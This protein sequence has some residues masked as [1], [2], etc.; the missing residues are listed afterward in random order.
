MPPFTFTTTSMQTLMR[1]AVVTLLT[2]YASGA[3]IKLQVY[4]GRPRTLYPPAAFPDSMSEQTVFTGP[5]N[6]QRTVTIETLVLWGLFDSAEAVAQRDAFCDGF[7]DYV[8]DNRDAVDPRA[9]ISA[10]AFQDLPNFVPDWIPP[11]EQ[12]SYY[13]TRIAVEGYVGG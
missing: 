2:D 11:E 13:A 8:T 5:K 10:I 9:T 4:P 1:A 12:L 3:S 7:A 6:R